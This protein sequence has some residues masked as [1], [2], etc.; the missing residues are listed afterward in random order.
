MRAFA[1][2]SA[3][4]GLQA[5]IGKS[6]LYTANVNSSTVEELE[7]L[8]NCGL[9]KLPFKYLSVPVSSKKLK[10]LDCEILADKITTRMR[11]WGSKNL[12]YAGRNLLIMSCSPCTL[13]GLVFLFCLSVYLKKFCL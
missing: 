13:I 2:F 12:S 8:T 3:S 4:S 6:A 1:T 5:N 11:S 9:G 10:A 7:E